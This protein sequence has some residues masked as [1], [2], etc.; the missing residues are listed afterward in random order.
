MA[1]KADDNGP[2]KE[3][4]FEAWIKE[5]MDGFKQTVDGQMKGFDVSSFKE[6]LRNAQKEQLLAM[7]SLLDSAIDFFDKDD[8]DTKK[9]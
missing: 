4:D 7:R 1:T 9:A 5:G 2:V 3:F 8:D 6:H